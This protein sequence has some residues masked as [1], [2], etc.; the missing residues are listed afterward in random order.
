MW[1]AGDTAALP[2]H[3]AC[4]THLHRLQQHLQ[5]LL[6][7]LPGLAVVALGVVFQ[8][9]HRLLSR[10]SASRTGRVCDCVSE[11]VSHCLMPNSHLVDLLRQDAVGA[12]VGELGARGATERRRHIELKAGRVVFD[13]VARGA[14][15]GIAGR[16]CTQAVQ[17]S[18]GV[19][20]WTTSRNLTT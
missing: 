4:A 8:L 6:V 17:Q 3:V 15:T 19:G 20:A 13:N 12:L 18:G 2:V 9:P 14:S 5:R 10:M 1:L 16:N 11:G 7:P